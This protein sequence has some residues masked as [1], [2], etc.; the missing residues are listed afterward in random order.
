VSYVIA[1]YGLVVATLAW[2]AWR[3]QQQRLRLDERERGDAP[4]DRAP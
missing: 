2:Y 3:V 4:E 1:A